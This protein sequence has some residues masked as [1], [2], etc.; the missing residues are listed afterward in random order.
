MPREPGISFSEHAARFLL[1]LPR[2]HRE[3][4]LREIERLRSTLHDA[5]ALPLKDASGRDLSVTHVRPWAITW[6]LHPVD[7]EVRILS[8]EAIR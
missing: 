5:K 3:R 6:W 8:I 4:L 7:W 1:A 2:A